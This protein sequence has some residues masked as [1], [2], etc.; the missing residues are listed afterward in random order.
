MALLKAAATGMSS[1]LL[2]SP[3][4]A[5]CFFSGEASEKG[6]QFSHHDRF[7][8]P[9]NSTHRHP[10]PPPETFEFCAREACQI[11]GGLAYSRGGQ[12]EKIE[13]LYRDAKAYRCVRVSP[14]P[15]F[16]SV[17]GRSSNDVQFL[18]LPSR[19]IP[20]GSFEIMFVLARFS[21]LVVAHC[22]AVH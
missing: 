20:G 5:S 21:P 11:F 16:F 7:F 13:R 3:L 18:Q 15:S 19:S 9:F 2:S 1:P 17:R 8:S 22:K 12:G 6:F 4:C 10:P 14:S